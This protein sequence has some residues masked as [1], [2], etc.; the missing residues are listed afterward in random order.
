[1]SAQISGDEADL[2]V[3]ALLIEWTRVV[4][5]NREAFFRGIQALLSVDEDLR[6]SCACYN[7]ASYDDDDVHYWFLFMIILCVFRLE[8]ACI[9]SW[10]CV[11][12][13]FRLRRLWLRY[14][15]GVLV[16]VCGF[17]GCSFINRFCAL[18]PGI[19]LFSL[20]VPGFC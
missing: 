7:L 11:A 12:V 19:W 1:M 10:V 6:V 4:M 14:S 3:P 17:Q 13:F 9:R 2:L 15:R 5:L 16:R 8:A 18:R 20:K